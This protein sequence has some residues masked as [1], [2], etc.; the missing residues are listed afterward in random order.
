MERCLPSRNKILAREVEI[1]A[2]A[3]IEVLWAC[4]NMRDFLNF[5][6]ICDQLQEK[7]SSSLRFQPRFNIFNLIELSSRHLM[8]KIS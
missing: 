3:D 6:P 4:L 2:N 5:F 1:H 8:Q 7:G